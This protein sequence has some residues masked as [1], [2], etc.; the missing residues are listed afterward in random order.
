MQIQRT[1]EEAGEE[2]AWHLLLPYI[3]TLVLCLSFML[4]TAELG[5]STMSKAW[6][7]D[8]LRG[9]WS[10][11]SRIEIYEQKSIQNLIIIE[12][13]VT[14]STPKEKHIASTLEGPVPWC[15]LRKW[16]MED[17]CMG[18]QELR[19]SVR[20]CAWHFLTV[21]GLYE[22]VGFLEPNSLGCNLIYVTYQ[23]CVLG[24]VSVHLVP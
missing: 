17:R 19:R 14:T 15:C 12:I 23:L 7:V 13:H 4:G 22:A 24:Q 16:A 10:T 21:S 8:S 3:L 9:C 20:T 1:A 6:R 5:T 11:F 2:R 18:G